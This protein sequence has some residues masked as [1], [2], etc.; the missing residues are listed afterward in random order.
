MLRLGLVGEIYMLLEPFANL[1]VER[2]LVKWVWK[3]NAPL[4]SDWIRE[5]LFLS[6]LRLKGGLAQKGSRALFK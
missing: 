1:E 2:V 4:S 3:W 6:S 5:H